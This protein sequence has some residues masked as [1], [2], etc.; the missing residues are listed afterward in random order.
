M[1]TRSP[2][3]CRNSASRH[4]ECCAHAPGA[5]PCWVRIVSGALNRPPDTYRTLAAWLTIWSSATSEKSAHMI[6]TIGRRPN[7]AAPT[8]LPRMADSLIGVSNTRS[9]YRPRSPRVT[10]NTPPGTPTSSP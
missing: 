6:S 7:I 3:T 8:A 2:G 10:P 9:P 1:H 5:L 4:C